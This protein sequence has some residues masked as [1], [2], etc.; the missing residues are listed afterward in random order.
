MQTP[1]VIE[2]N[3]D[4]NIFFLFALGAPGMPYVASRQ[5][6]KA[7]S[8][9]RIEI[10]QKRPDKNWEQ[11]DKGSKGIFRGPLPVLRWRCPISQ[12]DIC[13]SLQQS[14]NM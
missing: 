11:V 6:K 10:G 1:E 4:P 14:N 5:K 8:G 12:S 13:L 3:E 2:V 7:L 9:V